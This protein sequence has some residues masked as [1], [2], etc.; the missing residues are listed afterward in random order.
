MVDDA[1]WLSTT[2]RRRL[3]DGTLIETQAITHICSHPGC[4][5]FGSYLIGAKWMKGIRGTA[6]CREHLPVNEALALGLHT[7]PAQQAEA[8]DADQPDGPGG[9]P[10]G[11]HLEP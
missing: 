7:A 4:R 2:I 10:P 8:A 5:Q 3:K 11:D 1:K 9:F 6:Y